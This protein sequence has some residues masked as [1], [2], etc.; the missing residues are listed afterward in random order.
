MRLQFRI[1]DAN[2]AQD[3]NLYASQLATLSGMGFQDQGR[4]I[5]ALKRANGNL[6]TAVELIV[7]MEKKGNDSSSKGGNIRATASAARTMPQN[8]IP[9]RSS[10]MSA[11]VSQAALASL[12]AMGFDNDEENA[13]AL[14]AANG[15]LETAANM[16]LDAKNRK[17][18]NSSAVPPA[19]PQRNETAASPEFVLEPPVSRGSNSR[20]GRLPQQAVQ[21]KPTSADPFAGF[22]GDIFST[23]QQPQQPQQVA[24]SSN[25]L[26]DMFGNS[27]EASAQA[28]VPQPQPVRTA[29]AKESIMSLFNTPAQQP[30][31]MNFGMPHQ[32]GM[33]YPNQAGVYGQQMP[34]QAIFGVGPQSFG[35]QI[36]QQAMFAAGPQMTMQR[37]GM[38]I[39][40]GAGMNPFM[41]QQQQQPAYVYAP[42]PQNNVS[43]SWE[44][45]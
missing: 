15:S 32:G 37:M 8:Q 5:V 11:T 7:S 20:A 45:C 31:M 21:P 18:A 14:K 23:S 43:E 9:P 39:Q 40:Q 26:T 25:P 19:L 1:Q 27:N 10:S 13:Q 17:G 30:Q 36:P 12:R 34:Q 33:G 28:S 16:L 6:D 29:P 41:A 2:L 22:G 24:H 42:R 38:G 35:Q 4:N 3:A 44:D